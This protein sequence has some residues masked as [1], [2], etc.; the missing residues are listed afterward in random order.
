MDARRRQY[1]LH[2][3]LTSQPDLNFHNPQVQQALL[4]AMRFW[5]ARG[6]DGFR[7]DACNFHFH[8]RALRSNPPATNRDTKTVQDTNP[9]GM[10]A[11]IYDKTQPENLAFLQRVRS[12]LNEYGAIAI[13]EVGA[14]DSL[15]VMA[16]Y[17]EGDDKLHMAY[18]FIC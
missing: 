3:F 1:Y 6:V 10:Q 2:N 17:T 11:H 8:D 16:E 13:G 14:D 5:L 4:D 7:L 18:S 15:A 9:Y 12:L